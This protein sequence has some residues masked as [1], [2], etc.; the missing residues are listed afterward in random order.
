MN[1]EKGYQNRMT[2]AIFIEVATSLKMLG[3]IRSD[4]EFARMLGMND[5]WTYSLRRLGPHGTRQVRQSAAMRLRLR[6]DDWK[7]RANRP[8]AEALARLIEIMDEAD[9]RA[10]FMARGR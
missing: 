9:R 3:L 5:L 8:V 1:T 4:R 6:L 2:P 10:R 7:G